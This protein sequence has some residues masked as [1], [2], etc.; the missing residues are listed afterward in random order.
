MRKILLRSKG[1]K[2]WDQLA[3]SAFRDEAHLQELLYEDPRLIPFADLGEGVPEPRVYVREAGLPGSGSTDLI[4]VDEFG[5]ITIIECKL[6][7]NPE[8]KRK[9]VGQVLEYAAFLWRMSYDDFER[10]FEE[11][12]RT[13][14]KSGLAPL[15]A[16][17]DD[18][19]WSEEEFRAN[20]ESSLSVGNFVL[21]IAV[22]SLN[23][24]LRR[25]VE[26]RNRRSGDGE[27][28]CAVEMSY[29]SSADHE[30]L[31][32][33]ILGPEQASAK[34]TPSSTKWDRDA[35]FA[36]ARERLNSRPR[37]VSILEQLCDFAEKESDNC[38]GGR[39]KTKTF[40]FR[41]ERAGVQGSVFSCSSNGSLHLNFGFM[42][43]RVSEDDIARFQ[44]SLSRLP[45]F[46]DLADRVAKT[47]WPRY[48]V[49]E[50]LSSPGTMEDFK[51]AVL[52]VRGSLGR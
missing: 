11:E 30:V 19:E 35:F 5:G 22:D 31:A 16:P 24:E 50:V 13:A 52:A 49:E 18:A 32:P 25:I 23:E 1:K 6:A 4:G 17:P 20:V 26:Y 37:A 29:F 28:L 43:G 42:D 48:K 44:A 8:Q 14:G 33:R 3:E 45:E 40:T 46:G 12:Y 41:L 15:V 34:G 51:K 27:T 7:T 9:V 47:R 10:L 2:G 38:K 39:G 36:Q 21:V